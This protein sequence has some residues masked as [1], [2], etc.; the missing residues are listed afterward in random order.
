M[1]Q[2]WIAIHHPDD[3][4]RAVV[5][6]ESTRREIDA[7]NDEMRAAGV[8]IFAGGLQ[9]PLHAVSLSTLSDGQVIEKPGSHMK[10][11]DYL[12]GFWVLELE[13]MDQAVLWARKALAACK[14]P[15]EVRPFY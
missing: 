8:R 6:D 10:A 7:L 9:P 3:E 4:G 15:V 5:V 1:A 13:N 2:Y 11:S 14:V 12:G